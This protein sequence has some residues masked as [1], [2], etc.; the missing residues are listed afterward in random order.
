MIVFIDHLY[1]T[2]IHVAGLTSRRDMMFHPKYVMSNESSVVKRYNF[3]CIKTSVEK[4][5]SYR[6]TTVAVLLY[7]HRLA[8]PYADG[9]VL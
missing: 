3:Q 5:S 9:T 8:L 6:E 7:P 4:G 2:R 1:T